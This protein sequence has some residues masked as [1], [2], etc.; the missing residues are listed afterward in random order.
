MKNSKTIWWDTVLTRQQGEEEGEE[1]AMILVLN[2]SFQLYKLSVKKWSHLYY[3][4][5]GS[6][7]WLSISVYSIDS[8]CSDY[9]D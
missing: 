4:S 7:I 1:L 2:D 6:P 5:K 3:W 8:F 9:L